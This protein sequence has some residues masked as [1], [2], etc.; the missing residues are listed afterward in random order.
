MPAGLSNQ[1]ARLLTSEA[2]WLGPSCHS[3]N[4]LSTTPESQLCTHQGTSTHYGAAHTVEP[5]HRPLQPARHGACSLHVMCGQCFA[6][7]MVYATCTSCV[8]SQ[9][10]GV[11][12]PCMVAPHLGQGRH[13][14]HQ[15]RPGR[16]VLLHTKPHKVLCGVA[17]GRRAASYPWAA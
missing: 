6:H 5:G 17:A 9:A 7:G 8:G 14:R 2:S 4:P 11:W 3:L 12:P 16:P 1:G 13:A 10:P 15:I